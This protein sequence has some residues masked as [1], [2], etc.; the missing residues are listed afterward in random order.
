M[1]GILGNL[2]AQLVPLLIPVLGTLGSFATAYLAHLLKTKIGAEAVGITTELVGSVVS[3]LRAGMVEPL[4]AAASDGKLTKQEAEEIKNIGI[5]RVK[6]QIPKRVAKAATGVI[7]ELEA[8]VSGKIE[9]IIEDGKRP[10]ALL[11]GAPEE[12][13]P[14]SKTTDSS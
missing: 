2:L 9:Q 12:T 10:G 1:E 6:K 5:R 13:M 11:M 7:G 14:E 3:D 4:K 8:F